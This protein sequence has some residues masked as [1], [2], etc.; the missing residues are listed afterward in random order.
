M[1]GADFLVEIGTE[2]LPPKALR[3]LRDAFVAG[4]ARELD[5]ARLEHGELRAYASPRRLA[6]FVEGLAEG[7]EDRE[8]ELK[9]PP[10]SVAF[11]DSGA[12]RPAALAFAKR[13]GVGVDALGRLATDK[14]EWL[15]HRDVEK[16]TSSK[17]LL[18]SIA[19]AALRTLPI[20]RLMRWGSGD[21]EFVRPLHWLLM[22]HGNEIVEATVMGVEAGRETF[23]HRFHAPG[24]LSI[25]SP[26]EYVERLQNEGYVVA[27]LDERLARIQG[28]VE[29]AAADLGGVALGDEAL[30]D[31]V[32]A[33][34]EWPVPV[35][36]RFDRQFLDLPREVVVATLTSHQ[37]YFPVASHSGELLPAFITVSNIESREPDRVRE[38]NERVIRPRLA[39][40]AFF[41]ETDRRIPLGERLPKLDAVV[42]QKGLGS[43]G[44]KSRRVSALSASVAGTLDADAASAARAG[45]LAKC[46]LLTGMVGEFPELQGTMG[47]YYAGASGE[48][49][50]VALAIEE[51]YRPRFAGDAL[52]ASETG[53]C[54]S[55]ADKLDMLCGI[56]AVGKKP[57]GNRDP[58]GLRRAALGIVRVCIEGELD[59]DVVALIGQSL[60]AQPIDAGKGVGDDVYDFLIDR[61][62]AYA[63][64]QLGVNAETFEAVRDRRPSSLF[65]FALRLSAVRQFL[66]LEEA[67]SLAA[68]NKRIGNI[69][70][71]AEFDGAAVDSE[72]L[73][74]DAEKSLFA[75][76]GAARKAVV[77]MIG[78]RDYGGALSTLASLKDPVDRFFDDVMVMVED[79]ALRANRL[80]LLQALR[81]LFFE[82]AD[83]SRLVI[84]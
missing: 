17:E 69:L 72:M 7:Q 30:Y 63:L 12:A 42:Y 64:E 76:L 56:F 9:G 33:L 39:D 22:L 50:A 51:Q 43:I 40:A 68:A 83:I 66:E 18:G 49:D 37:R 45:L 29:A 31:E 79:D 58:F 80:G 60:S 23:G 14:G 78:S 55:V 3:Q 1:A 52:P 5:A 26:A 2:E 35:V 73:L 48:E 28:A 53:R 84:R 21:A 15:V 67:E 59:L 65:D 8:I 82:V 20:P 41:W 4:V 36:G 38:G 6:V 44:D 46:D 57:G 74:E 27:D 61:L 25:R 70:R 47:R 62:R 77:P 24:S 13:C 81:D 75:A 16:G 34:V 54:V 32:A 11:D 19:A 10:V 71:Q